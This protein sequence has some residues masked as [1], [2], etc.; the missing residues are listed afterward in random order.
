[1]KMTL[2]IDDALLARV[3]EATGAASK[4]AA[5]DLALRE[6]DRKAKLVKLTS[7][8]LG[9]SGDALREAFDPNYNLEEL[10]A[11]ETPVKYGRNTR[12]RR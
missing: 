6:V 9:A 8:G 10:R 3:M 2:H 12:S 4:T 5:V 7:E 1:M 11:R